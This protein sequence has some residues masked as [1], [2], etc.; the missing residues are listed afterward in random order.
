MLWLCTA[1]KPKQ[2]GA[3]ASPEASDLVKTERQT[4][5]QANKD[6]MV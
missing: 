1:G 5:K 6:L 2:T 3:G 4:S